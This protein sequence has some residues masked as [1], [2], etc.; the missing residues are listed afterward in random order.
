LAKTK[1]QSAP[2]VGCSLE[3]LIGRVFAKGKLLIDDNAAEEVLPDKWQCEDGLCQR[4]NT[5]AVAFTDATAV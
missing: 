2:V 3:K 1:K 4:A 5:M